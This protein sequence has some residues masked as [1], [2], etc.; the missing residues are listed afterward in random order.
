MGYPFKTQEDGVKFLK[1]IDGL[2]VG[3]HESKH[4]YT[5]EPVGFPRTVAYVDTG[6]ML[7]FVDKGRQELKKYHDAIQMALNERFLN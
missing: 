5:A 1:S 2:D 4:L 6:G 3:R 7:Y